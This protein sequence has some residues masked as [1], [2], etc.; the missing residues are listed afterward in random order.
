MI[1][2]TDLDSVLNN[3]LVTWLDAYNQDHNDTVTCDDIKTWNTHLYVK[4]GER[5]YNYLTPELLTRC[6]PMPGAVEVTAKLLAQGHQVV[7]VSACGKGTFDAKKTWLKAHFPHLKHFIAT[8]SKQFVR[9]D[10]L[11]DD[12]VHNLEPFPGVGIAFGTYAY[13]QHWTGRRAQTWHNVLDVLAT[14]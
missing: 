4:C 5:I 10:V 7:V 8:H 2:A 3:L 14:I 6:S 13:N 11:I 1:I 9:A 12:A